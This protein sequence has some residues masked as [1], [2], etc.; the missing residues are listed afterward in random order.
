M[1]SFYDV[2]VA[3]AEVAFLYGAC[4]VERQTQE[5]DVLRFYSD[6]VA[7]DGGFG[8]TYHGL[9]LAD[10]GGV[11][12]AGLFVAYGFVHGLRQARVSALVKSEHRCD[13][14]HHQEVAH[15]ILVA[16]GYVAGGLVGHVNVVFLIDESLEC[17]SHR[18]Y[19]VV[20]VG[21]EHYHALGV[22]IGTFGTICVVGVGLA[23][24]HPVMVC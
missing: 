15:H 24:S 5:V 18:Y 17:A 6:I 10:V 20:G 14:V 19:V 2:D 1:R 22:G 16:Y 3:L 8:L 12:V 4:F 21:A 23:S 7:G 13:L 11:H 9:D